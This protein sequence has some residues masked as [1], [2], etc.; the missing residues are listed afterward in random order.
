MSKEQF[1][2]TYKKLNNNC[3]S[4]LLQGTDN[5]FYW[6]YYAGM[7]QT[8][9]RAVQQEFVPIINQMIEDQELVRG[10]NISIPIES[11]DEIVDVYFKRWYLSE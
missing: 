6:S 4:D 7:G 10:F 1:I 9:Y 3:Q 11:M 2:Q 5:N 8:S